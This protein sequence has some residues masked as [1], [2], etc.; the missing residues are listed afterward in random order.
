MSIIVNIDVMLARRKMSSGELAEAVGIT[1]SNLS[2]LKNGKATGIR[3]S[4]NI[5]NSLWGNS[6]ILYRKI[7]KTGKRTQKRPFCG[8]KAGG[9][10]RRTQKQEF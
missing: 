7:A 10:D 6:K 9:T 1:A 8:R 5:V 2:I 3:F 4:S